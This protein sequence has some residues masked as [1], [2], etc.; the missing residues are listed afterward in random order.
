MAGSFDGAGVPAKMTPHA[1]SRPVRSSR[2][3]IRLA[4]T[5]TEVERARTLFLEYREWLVAHREVTAF[6]DDVL[7]RG[8]KIMD[9]E[10]EGLPG[11][12]VPPRGALYL[13]WAG[14]DPIGC[15]ALRP[16][17]PTTAEFKRLFVRPSSR[18]SGVGRDLTARALLRA[19]K[20]GYRRV[21]LD[22]LPTMGRA[23]A[24]YRSM[25]FLPIAA[26]WKHPVPGALFFEIR[27]PLEKRAPSLRTAVVRAP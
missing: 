15:A 12:Y 5:P 3:S 9:R 11:E 26:Y 24:L 21:V 25:G 16:L 1:E 20:V 2:L 10:I 18:S 4:T 23:I 14:G 6:P 22:T 19:R 13:A 27:L 8:L 17:G 7:A